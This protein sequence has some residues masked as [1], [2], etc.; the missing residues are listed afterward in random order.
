MEWQLEHRNGTKGECIGWLDG[1]FP[2]GLVDL[3][4]DP[5]A[6]QKRVKNGEGNL[7]KRVKR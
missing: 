3:S 1:H 6:S 2:G 4:L 7:A 5:L